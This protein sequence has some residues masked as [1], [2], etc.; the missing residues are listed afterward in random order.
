MYNLLEREVI[1]FLSTCVQKFTLF[2]WVKFESGKKTRNSCLFKWDILKKNTNNL[3]RTKN[4]YL[5][6]FWIFSYIFSLFFIASDVPAE[7]N[8][9][10]IISFF[11]VTWFYQL[12][13]LACMGFKSNNLDDILTSVGS[14]PFWSCVNTWSANHSLYLFSMNDFVVLFTD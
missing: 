11:F 12:T 13:I 6:R 7:L 9:L 10:N 1:N 4:N 3:T 2:I 8:P 5:N 14:F